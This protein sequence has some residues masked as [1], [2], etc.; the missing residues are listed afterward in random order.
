MRKCAWYFFQLDSSEKRR[1]KR[2]G[3]EAF[4]K[5]FKF[6]SEVGA[7]SRTIYL[8]TQLN[9]DNYH[10]YVGRQNDSAYNGFL[11]LAKT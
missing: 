9:I 4:T 3:Y 1:D 2:N 8:R 7:R 11:N 6:V 5:D 10:F